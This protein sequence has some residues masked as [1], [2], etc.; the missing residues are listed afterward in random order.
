MIRIILT[1]LLLSC[2]IFAETK[3]H[4]AHDHGVKGPN[5]GALYEVGKVAVIEFI[6]DEGKG[7]VKV[8][9]FKVGAKEKLM[10]EKAPRL[11]VM[12]DKGRKQVKTTAIDGKEKSSSFSAM[13]EVLKGHAEMAVSI[14]VDGKP[15]II[16]VDHVHAH[17]GHDH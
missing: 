12:V 11:N 16:K 14:K 15:Y 2:S 9:V 3:G 13:N 17:K 5:G 10:L 8:F 6:H 7:L 4:E 1:A